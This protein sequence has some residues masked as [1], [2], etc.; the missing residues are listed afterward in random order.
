MSLV[1]NVLVYLY[2]VKFIKVAV[3]EN[4]ACSNFYCNRVG[5]LVTS[6]AAE[7]CIEVYCKHFERID[8]WS[9]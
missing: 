1:M 7:N 5:F 4:R 2:V 6:R 9:L 8:N 3:D